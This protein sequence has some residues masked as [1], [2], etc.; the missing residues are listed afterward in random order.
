MNSIRD[1]VLRV[2]LGSILGAIGALVLNIYSD[3]LPRLMPALQGIAPGTYVNIILLLSLVLLLVVAVAITL[4]LKTRPYRP[5][6]LWGKAFGFKWSAELDYSKERQDEVEIQLQWLC[7]RHGIF[8][9]VKS[10]EVPDAAYSNLWCPKC[11]RIYEM[12]SQGDT[13]YVEEADRIVRR[14]ILSR[15]RL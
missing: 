2:L 14:E 11:N 8:L 13:V 1:T 4:Y 9:N 7:P 5:H 12:K 6:S 10:A 3:L 15:L